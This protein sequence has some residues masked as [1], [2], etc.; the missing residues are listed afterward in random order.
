LSDIEESF[1]ELFAWNSKFDKSIMSDL[2]EYNW[3]II[4][5]LKSTDFRQR[6]TKQKVSLR[7]RVINKCII[8]DVDINQN[9]KI[10]IDFIAF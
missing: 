5:L 6:K 4:K 1:F 9:R 7:E 3:L 8:D 10:D 2:I